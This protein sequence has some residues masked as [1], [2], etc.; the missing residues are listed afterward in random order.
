MSDGGYSYSGRSWVR[1]LVLV[2]RMVTI[3]EVVE[4][5]CV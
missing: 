1:Y 5:V 2:R 3:V 4:I